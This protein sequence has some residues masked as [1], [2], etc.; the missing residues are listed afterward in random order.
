MY[1]QYR[2]TVTISLSSI[3]LTMLTPLTLPTL[4]HQHRLSIISSS[5]TVHSS[6]HKHTLLVC[7]CSHWLQTLFTVP[8]LV[9][10]VVSVP[11]VWSL[12]WLCSCDKVRIG[13]ICVHHAAF[14]WAASAHLFIFTVALNC[15]INLASMTEWTQLG[16]HMS[17]PKTVCDKMATSWRGMWSFFF[18]KHNSCWNDENASSAGLMTFSTRCCWWIRVIRY[19]WNLL[20]HSSFISSIVKDSECNSCLWPV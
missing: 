10:S 4:Q 19:W 5:G 6:Q 11:P 1:S 7:C 9:C 2:C 16:F 12:C 17:L 20:I 18:L 15:Q 8:G 13:I 3:T 14:L